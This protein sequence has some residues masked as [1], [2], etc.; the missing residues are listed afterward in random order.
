MAA[1]GLWLWSSPYRYEATQAHRLNL[2]ENLIPLQC[3]NTTLFGSSIPLTSAPLNRISLVFYS[4]F[5]V[6]CLNL[7][8]PAAFFLLLFMRYENSS[9]NSATSQG[10]NASSKKDMPCRVLPST[11]PLFVNALVFV[12]TKPIAR[13]MNFMKPV[14]PILTGLSFL[15]AIDIVFIFDIETTIKRAIPYQDATDESKWTFGQTLA[16]LLLVLP[17]RDIYDYIKESR[18]AEHAARSKEYAAQCTEDLKD[19]VKRKDL[20][21]LRKAALYADDVNAYVDGMFSTLCSNICKILKII[22]WLLQ[23]SSHLPFSLQHIRVTSRLC[24]C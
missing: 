23:L 20:D 16:L 4:V 19:A 18:E 6:P 9:S 15:L 1:L 10:E 7:V 21:L 11:R 14:W 5:L 22:T 17:M 12:I 3:T 13:V 24:V 2:T 8:I